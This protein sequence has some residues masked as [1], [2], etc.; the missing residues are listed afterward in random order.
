MNGS[1]R[2]VPTGPITSRLTRL[3]V[4]LRGP[5]TNDAS[6]AVP[7]NWGLKPLATRSGT[8]RS[9]GRPNLPQKRSGY[10]DNGCPQ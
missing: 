2:R 10:S 1:T 8:K 7:P 3:P 9:S 4:K 6:V 5:A